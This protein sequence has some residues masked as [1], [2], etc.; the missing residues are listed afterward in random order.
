MD[1]HQI[2]QLV[3]TLGGMITVLKRAEPSE[4]LEI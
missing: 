2:Q 1:C 4:K 3:D